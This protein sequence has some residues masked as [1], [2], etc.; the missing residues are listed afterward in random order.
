MILEKVYI[1][2]GKLFSLACLHL[3]MV[4]DLELLMFGLLL[5]HVRQ[6]SSCNVAAC[7]YG[8]GMASLALAVPLLPCL[9]GVTA[10]FLRYS[11]T[12]APLASLDIFALI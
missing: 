3:Q 4:G 9:L 12:L 8:L 7:Y 6:L 5:G 10:L 1:T 11:I 2:W